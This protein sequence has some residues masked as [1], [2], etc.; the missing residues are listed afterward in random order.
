MT[1]FIALI[2]ALAGLAVSS[3]AAY[4]KLSAAIRPLLRRRRFPIAILVTEEHDREARR[5]VV[6]LR[7]AGFRD[8]Q[9]TRSPATV[10]GRYA[11][12]VWQPA[13][14][15][16][17]EAVRT[18]AP[19]ATILVYSHRRIEGLRLSEDILACNSKLRLT[20]DLSTLA[21]LGR[22]D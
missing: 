22:G 9:L 2:A 15:D 21:A 14:T 20:G 4:T 5:F 6:E 17:V 18:A 11:V 1:T 19:Q 13:G 16:G 7:K 8:I 10:L 3:L 12:V